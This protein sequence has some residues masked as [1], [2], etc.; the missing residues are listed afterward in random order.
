MADEHTPTASAGDSDLDAPK[1]G[2][3]EAFIRHALARFKLAEEAEQENRKEALI[4][5]QFRNL[6]QW[7]KAVKAARDAAGR[8]A[9]TVD[10]INHPIRQVLNAQRQARPGIKVNPKGSGARNIETAS[11]VRGLIRQIEYDS[12][13]EDAYDWAFDCAASSGLGYFRIITEWADSPDDD[14]EAMFDQEIK[15][16]KI[17]NKYSVYPDPTAQLP[18]KSDARFYFVTEDVPIEEYKRLYPK[19]LLAS[20]SGLTGLGDDQ[21]AWC[22]DK[23]IRIAE[24]WYTEQ[25]VKTA[26]RLQGGRTVTVDVDQN[27]YKKGA[28]YQ[29]TPVMNCR[30]VDTRV[31]KI[32]KINCCEILEGND[33]LT[34]GEDWQGQY[35]PIVPA[36]GEELFIDGKRVY[37]G[38]IRPAR[39]SQ[40]MANYQAS[41]LVRTL[42]VWGRI[43]WVGAYGQFK[44]L[45]AKW[46]SAN[47]EDY[48]Y[49]EYNPVSVEGH[50]APPPS[51]NGQ[52]PPIQAIVIGYQASVDDIKASMGFFDASLGNVNPKDRSGR[53]ILALQQQGELG[54]SNFQDN[55]R[56][57]MTF[58]GKIL[59][60]LIPYVYGN[61]P[62][63]IVT[64]LGEDEK[65]A[66]VMFNQPFLPGETPKPIPDA[67]GA[68]ITDPNHQLLPQQAKFYDLKNAKFSVAVTVGR[69]HA[70]KRIEM[71]EGIGE[72][73]QN[74]AL[75]PALAAPYVR[76]QDWDGAEEMADRLDRA[77][78]Q[79]VKQ[80]GDQ[81]IPPQ[82]RSYIAQ[83]EQQHQ[84]LTMIVNELSK[85]IET[86]QMELASKEK[87]AGIQQETQLAIADLKAQ[88]DGVKATM[89]TIEGEKQRAHETNTR[90]FEAQQART[91]QFTQQAHE[92][93]MEAEARATAMITQ[94]TTP[95]PAPAN[96]N[97]AGA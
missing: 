87:I 90:E 51:R 25:I 95:Q 81:E 73:M 55:L 35:I 33:D 22:S 31:V 36:I 5:D 68:P 41:E 13:A 1:P 56:R 74:E 67:A 38:M 61:R 46:N 45:E 75:A 58:A 47:I 94:A 78:P 9:L 28:S 63:R 24:Y 52:E 69:S 83:L 42:A 64:V 37:R 18:D 62:G 53:A 6:E 29:G 27:L 85:T 88:I 4:D 65:P 57:S 72:L 11:R 59:V 26:I 80:E 7:D 23:T 20:A 91:A 77:F 71:K 21:R 97:G 44:N 76:A 54:S 40:R 3:Q 70:T 92:R 79:F 86:K 14:P 12:H 96:G 15:I 10:K 39:D 19:S 34:A 82:V 32:A 30:D 66:A 2:D 49:L 93:G 17:L 60:D 84:Q 43:P 48:P 16:R 50:L 89:A 8:P